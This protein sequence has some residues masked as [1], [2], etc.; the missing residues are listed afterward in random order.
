[1]PCTGGD[2]WGARVL[3]S[4][5]SAYDDTAGCG[6]FEDDD[7]ED[8][9]SETSRAVTG[10]ARPRAPPKMS[11][12]L[13]MN[14]D[15]GL[16]DGCDA[17]GDFFGD[18]FGDLFGDFAALTA[19]RD[20]SAASRRALATSTTPPAVLGLERRDGAAGEG[21]TPSSHPSSRA[22]F[23]VSGCSRFFPSKLTFGETCLAASS[24][25]TAARDASAASRRALATSTTPPAV[26]GLERRDGAA[27]CL[28]YTSPSP[29]D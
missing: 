17:F 4:C 14:A 18:F 6:I 1:M 26:L 9:E 15:A 11:P 25:L 19:A 12:V 5:A 28:L 3:R 29:R 13:R 23:G 24:A 7:W 10:R 21:E 2:G 20:A 27:G 22:D 16:D 8:V